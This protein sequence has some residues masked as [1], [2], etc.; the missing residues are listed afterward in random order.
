MRNIE[1]CAPPLASGLLIDSKADYPL[2][3][4]GNR[5]V[6]QHNDG[7]VFERS[8]TDGGKAVDKRVLCKQNP[9]QELY[10]EVQFLPL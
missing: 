1:H 2:N 6:L 3:V 9:K 5:T 4:K 8:A 7:A 10:K